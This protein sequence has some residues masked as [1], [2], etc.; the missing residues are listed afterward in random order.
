MSSVKKTPNAKMTS[1][2]L[3]VNRIPSTPQQLNETA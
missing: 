3:L 1:T 2:L